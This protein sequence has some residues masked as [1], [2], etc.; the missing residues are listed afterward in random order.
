MTSL[1]DHQPLFGGADDDVLNGDVDA[2]IIHGDAGNDTIFGE[3]GDDS[4]IGG[5]GDDLLFGGSGANVLYGGAGADFLS[6]DSA[7]ADGDLQ[8]LFGGEGDNTLVLEFTQEDYLQPGVINEV[9]QYANAL[10]AGENPGG[11]GEF[12]FTT[13]ALRT[14]GFSEIQIFVDG[15]QLAPGEIPGVNAVD[16][17][18]T[19]AESGSVSGSVV[20]NDNFPTGAIVSLLIGPAGGDLT[21]ENDGSFTFS[22]SGAFE[23]LSN[24]DTETVTFIYRLTDDRGIS[25]AVV[26]IN[27]TGENDEPTAGV[28]AVNTDENQPVSGD[29]I[30]DSGAV[31]IDRNDVLTVLSVNGQ[32]LNG[33]TQAVTLPSGAVIT[34]A[35]AGNYTYAPGAAFDS[36]PDGA[37]DT[38]VIS[39]IVSDGQ[40]GQVASELTVTV[41]GANDAPIANA[42]AAI[43]TEDDNVT[44]DVLGNDTDVDQGDTLTLVSIDSVS[45]G[46]NAVI[47]P[48]GQIQFLPGNAFQTLSVGASA[49]VE[50]A[51]TIQDASGAQSSS[52][53]TVTVTG[54][55]DAPTADDI[56][57]STSEDAA[58]TGN[59]ISEANAQDI[60]S[61]DVLNITE[62][63]GVAFMGG[64]SGPLNS[65][66]ELTVLANGDFTYLPTPGFNG[67][68][69]GET[70]T[71]SFTFTI[72]DGRG[73]V[74][75]QSFTVEVTGENDGPVVQDIT[76]A[77]DEND[78]TS[79]DFLA[80]SNA[81]DPDDNGVLALAAVNGATPDPQAPPIAGSNGGE[82]SVDPGGDFTFDTL[83]DFEELSVGDTETT[84][85]TF[86][87]EDD[88]G[89]TITR[90]L[91]FEVEGTNDDPTADPVDIQTDEDTAA[92][93][94][95]L[96]DS[97]AFDIDQN[98]TLTIVEIRAAG[99]ADGA[100]NGAQRTI[101]LP[102]GASLTVSPD[103][104]YSYTP[105]AQFQSLAEGDTGAANFSFRIADGQGGDVLVNVDVA[106][107]GLND[108]PTADAITRGASEDATAAGDLLADSN[109]ADVDDG[110]V[111]RIAEVNG[112]QVVT[113]GVTIAGAD[114]GSLFVNDQGAYTFNPDGDFEFL[115]V[116]D[117][118]TS[119]FTFR[120]ADSF[121]GFVDQDITFNIAGANDVPLVNPIDSTTDE[122]TA[123]TGNFIVDGGASDIDQNDVLA[124]SRIIADGVADG[125]LNGASRTFALASGAQLTVSPDG[126]Y[127]Y[128][129][130]QAFQS[131]PEGGSGSDTLIYEVVDSNGGSAQESL[132]I[133][134]DGVNDAPTLDAINVT[135]GENAN[136]E[137]DL[138]NDSNAADIDQGDTV[139]IFTV[140]GQGF[141]S[142][143][144]T[145]TRPGEG[146]LVADGATYTYLTLTDFDRLSVGETA[147][148][149][150]DFTVSDAFGATAS[151]TIN[152]TITGEND[153]PTAQDFADTTTEDDVLAGNLLSESNAQDVDQSDVLTITSFEADGQGQID[154]N[155]AEASVDFASGI[156]LTVGPDGAYSFDPNGSFEGLT[157]GESITEEFVFTI[158]DGNGGEITRAASITING[159]N[160]APVAVD[161]AATTDQNTAFDIDILFNDSDVDGSFTLTSFTQP[162]AGGITSNGNDVFFDPNGDFDFLA[163]GQQTT[164]TFTY[165]I[166]DNEGAIDTA[167]VVVTITGLNDDPITS[168]LTATTNEDQANFTF[169]LL[170]GQIDV[171]DGDV[172]SIENFAENTTVFGDF[173]IS[174]SIFTFDAR[175]FDSLDAGDSQ[176]IV[177]DYDVVDAFGARASNQLTL[178]VEG[179]DEGLSAVDDNFSTDEDTILSD[180]VSLND[181]FGTGTY[182]LLQDVDAGLLTFNS[183]GTFT[184]DPNGEFD[185]LADGE[186]DA[187]TFTYAIDDGVQNSSATATI[188]IFGVNDGPLADDVLLSTD[189]DTS[190]SFNLIDESNASDPDGAG[191][192][193]LDS[194]AGVLLPLNFSDAFITLGSG[195]VVQAN[196]DGEITY[197]PSGF[198]DNLSEGEFGSDSFTF[199]L[200]DDFGDSILVSADIDI[201]G[202][203]DPVEADDAS[204]AANEDAGFAG[205]LID[206]SDASDVDASDEILIGDVEGIDVTG[207]D[208]ISLASGA[209]LTID[210]FGN[211]TYDTS[212]AF[213]TLAVGETGSDAFDYSITDGSSSVDLTADI[214]VE[215]ANDDVVI[216]VANSDLA[217]TFTSTGGSGAGG[218]SQ[219]SATEL[220]G[221]NGFA[222]FGSAN[223]LF[224]GSAVAGDG[225]FDGDG[226][227]DLVIGAFGYSPVG[228]SNTGTAFVLFGDG[229]ATAPA[230]RDIPAIIPADDGISLTGQDNELLGREAAFVGD[231][232]GD[233]FDDFLIGNSISNAN[234]ADN[235]VARL[236]FG[237]DF[238]GVSGYESLDASNSTNFI[239]SSTGFDGTR[240][241]GSSVAL[242][243]DI[244]NDGIND[245]I[246]GASFFTQ[247]F[248]DDFGK[249]FVVFGRSAADAPFGETFDLATLDGTNG[250]KIDTGYSLTGT[251]L[252][253][254]ADGI[255]DVNGDGLDDL[256]IGAPREI[257]FVPDGSGGVNYYNTGASYVIYGSDSAFGASVD[258]TNLAAGEG[259]R[260]VDN[261]SNSYLG[262]NV[263][264][265]GDFNGDGIDDF[266]ISAYYDDG[267]RFNTQGKVFVVFGTGSDIA[268][269]LD[270]SL[271]TPS[272]GIEIVGAEPY[273]YA[274]S[275]I[276][277]A[278]DF[279][280][281]GFDDLLIG[282][283]RD[284]EN[285]YTGQAY[286]LFGTDQQFSSPFNLA[287]FDEDDGVLLTGFDRGD[288][289]GSRVSAAGD[290]NEDGFDDVIVGAQSAG[291]DGPGAA[292]VFFGAASGGGSGGG[293]GV[294]VG[295]TGSVFF[296]DVDLTDAH[297]VSDDSV[298]GDVTFTFELVTDSTGGLTGEALWTA[299]IDD[300][301]FAMLAEGETVDS[302][303]NVTIDDGLGGAATETIEVTF[304]GIN[305]APTAANVS[306]TTDEDTIL[307]DGDLI[308]EGSV[309]DID[310]GDIV[311][312]STIS[313]GTDS[314]VQEISL[315]ATPTAITINDAILT[316]DETGA[317]TLDPDDAFEFLGD[318]DMFTVNFNFEAEDLAGATVEASAAITITGI[319]DAPT[320][321]DDTAATD[322]DTDI[323]IS[324]FGND[325]DPEGGLTLLSVDTMGTLATV[326]I[327]DPMAGTITFDPDGNF[328][329]LGAGEEATDTFTYTLEDSGGLQSTAEVEVTVMGL[330]DAPVASNVNVSVSED[331]TVA[332]N[333]LSDGGGLD[334]DQNDTLVV[335]SING[336]DVTG[337]NQTIVLASG[338][339]LLISPNGDFTYNPLPGMLQTLA[340]GDMADDVISVVISDGDLTDTADLVVSV[341]GVNDAPTATPLE[342]TTNEDE[343]NFQID[344]LANAVE[345]DQGDVLSIDAFTETPTGFGSFILTGTDLFYDATIFGDLDAGETQVVD[346][347][348]DIVDSQGARVSTTLQL[349]IEGRDE[350]L[351]A[352]DDNFAT[353]EDTPISGD[354]STN[355]TDQG[356]VFSLVT[357]PNGD[358]T[359]NAD[360]TF[361]YD[362]TTFFG[363]LAVGE[364]ETDTFTYQIDN[365]TDTVTADVTITID[366][367]NDGPQQALPFVSLVDLVSLNFAQDG[368]SNSNSTEPQISGDG[369]VVVFESAS[370]VLVDADTNIAND[371]FVGSASGINTRANIRDDNGEQITDRSSSNPEI[372]GDGTIVVFQSASRQLDILDDAG[373]PIPN[374]NATDVFVRDENTGE[375]EFITLFGVDGLRSNGDSF[376]ASISENGRFVA[377]NSAAT[378]LSAETD[379]NAGISDVFLHDRQTGETKLISQQVGTVE[380]SAS[381]QPTISADGSTVVFLTGNPLEAGDDNNA[382]DVYAYDV[383]SETLELVSQNSASTVGNNDATSAFG[384]GSSTPYVSGNGRYVTWVSN[385]TNLVE[386][387]PGVF[388]GDTNGV[389]DI[390][391][392]DLFF[393]TTERISVSTSGVEANNRSVRPQISDDGRFVSYS[394][395]ASN[396][397][398]ELAD[399]NGIEDAFVYDRITKTTTRVSVTP[400][401]SAQP[402]GIIPTISANGDFI[403]FGSF[404]ANADFDSRV[405]T[406]GPADIYVANINQTGFNFSQNT[407][408][409][410]ATVDL[411]GE[412]FDE[413]GDLLEI[414]NIVVTSDDTDRSFSFSDAQDDNGRVIGFSLDPSEFIDLGVNDYELLTAT[415]DVTDGTVTISGVTGVVIVGEN[416]VPTA[417]DQMFD[418]DQGGSV[419]GNFFAMDI[420]GDE[421]TFSFDPAS[422]QGDLVLDAD[423]T[424]TYTS[425]A[426]QSADETI[427]INV[428]DGNGGLATFEAI[429]NVNLAP[430]FAGADG[431]LIALTQEVD[432]AA[433]NAIDVSTFFAD[434]EGTGLTYTAELADGGSL[435]NGLTIDAVSGV[436]SGT[437]SD[438]NNDLF[439]IAVTATDED[440]LNTT[441]EFWLAVVDQVVLGDN[442]D[443]TIVE[444]NFASFIDGLGGNDNIFGDDQTDIYQYTRGDGFDVLAED[445]F[446][447]RDHLILNGYDSTEISFQR[448]FSNPF[449]DNGFDLLITPSGSAPDFSEG[450]LVRNGLGVDGATARISD[451]NFDDG[452]TITDTEV[453]AMILASEATDGDDDIRG[454]SGA[455]TLAGGLGDDLLAGGDSADTYIINAGEGDDT[456][457]DS[458][459][460]DN[461]EIQFT[462]SF[463]GV[464]VSNQRD[465]DDFLFDF[466]DGSS[467]LV[468]NTATNSNS[469][470]IASYVFSDVTL[471][472]QD[473]RDILNAQQTTAGDDLIFG[474]DF[475]GDTLVG[476]QGDDTLT[477][478]RGDDVYI[479][480]EGDG[481][482]V[483][484]EQG[485]NITGDDELQVS[486]FELVGSDTG[487]GFEVVGSSEVTFTRGLDNLNTVLI[488]L[489]NASGSTGSIL[490]EGGISPN[491]VNDIERLTFE[492]PDGAGGT[493]TIEVT[494]A[495]IRSDVLRQAETEGDDLIVG[496]SGVDT[497]E[498]GQGDDTLIGG[499]GVDTYIF[500]IGDGD[501]VI[502]DNGALQNDDIVVF[503]DRAFADVRIEQVSTFNNNDLIITA[504]TDSI[505]VVGGLSFVS[506]NSVSEYQFTDQTVTR[507]QMRD[508]LIAQAI[509]EG[510][511]PIGTSGVDIYPTTPGGDFFFNGFGGNDTYTFAPGDGDDTVTDSGG[512][513][514]FD[515]LDI[516]A[517]NSTDFIAAGAGRV[518]LN[519]AFEDEAIFEIG[520]DSLTVVGFGSFE[521]IQFA[522]QSF[523]RDGND[524]DGELNFADFIAAN[525]VGVRIPIVG[526]S[527]SETFTSTSADETFVGG[528]GTDTYVFGFDSSGS[529]IGDDTVSQN[530]GSTSGLR[531]VIDFSGTGAANVVEE[532]VRLSLDPNNRFDLVLDVIYEDSAFLFPDV[533][534]GRFEEQ[535]KIND[536]LASFRELNSIEIID[537]EGNSSLLNSTVEI[538]QIIFDQQVTS[539]DD[540]IQGY[541]RSG[542]VF[543]GGAGNDT[544]IGDQ[545]FDTY[546]FFI[547]DEKDLIADGFPQG[548]GNLLQIFDRSVAD[549]TLKRDPASA[550]NLIIDFGDDEVTISNFFIQTQ[551]A[552]YEFNA[553]NATPD[554]F[555]PG[556]IAQLFVDSQSTSGDDLIT[557]GVIF[558]DTLAGG[559]GDDTLRGGDSS[560]TYILNA[561]EGND[562]VGD[563][564]S[565]VGGDVDVLQFD[566]AS[567]EVTFFQNADDPLNF[568]LVYD[569]GGSVEI[570]RLAETNDSFESFVFTDLTFTRDEIVARAFD[571]LAT[572]GDDRII[573]SASDNDL[574]GGLGDDYVRGGNGTDSFT[575]N[576]GDGDD[577]LG[578][579]STA[580]NEFETVRIVGVDIDD[581]VLSRILG[582]R[583]LDSGQ[584][585][586]DEDLLISFANDAGSIVY[587]NGLRQSSAQPRIEIVD[588][589]VTLTEQEIFNRVLANDIANGRTFLEGPA[590]GSVTFPTGASFIF[591][592]QQGD[593]FQYEA[594][595]GALTI[596]DDAPFS[597]TQRLEIT[598]YSS[599]DATF[600]RLADGVEDFIVQLPG[601]D[602]IIVIGDVSGGLPVNGVNEIFF[603][604]DNIIFNDADIT[605]LIDGGSASGSSGGGGGGGSPRMVS[606]TAPEVTEEAFTVT[607]ASTSVDD[608]LVL[609]SSDDVMRL[610]A[611]DDHVRALGGADALW[612][613]AGDDTLIGNGGADT[614]RGGAGEDELRGGGGQDRL[615]GG[616]GDDEL[617]G[618]GGRDLLKGGRG[619]DDLKGGGGSDVL[620]GGGG[621]DRIEGGKGA[622]RLQGQGGEDTFVFARGFGSDVI[623]DFRDGVDVIDFSTHATVTAFGDLAISQVG[624]DAIITDGVGGRIRLL[625]VDENDLQADDF[626]F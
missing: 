513:A 409:I 179:R 51:Y 439:R 347:T 445:G 480:N 260:I 603:A 182:N 547:G 567:T 45:P 515:V 302:T 342:R 487:N 537:S 453:R 278:G 273:N 305:D 609:S 602:Q 87:I 96:S 339:E 448:F 188:D 412:F 149:S 578:A 254:A 13:F 561:N 28:A 197:D 320:A 521:R 524:A 53:A 543:T 184:F 526:N 319:N 584:A 194:L 258:V 331:D 123:T 161:D 399:T 153:G 14:S 122:D 417:E 299:I 209:E 110:D 288:T 312:I 162:S 349:T 200:V 382:I 306:R 261:N 383:E 64:F 353:D 619:E 56:A 243:G 232:N 157:T 594:G 136:I 148:T 442:D 76:I 50:I 31:D 503:A 4:L 529:N 206:L 133:S 124:V 309:M 69:V 604:G 10:A 597:E 115:S 58:I 289:F 315:G 566:V 335:Q 590:T 134:I 186:Q 99:L 168:P 610:G 176:V 340:E 510:S 5:L 508:F 512:A 425:A 427:S 378:N 205:D 267:S 406:G 472:L 207:G 277:S 70:A 496:F 617:R 501:D 42:D 20:T 587:E 373:V 365:G 259:F 625:D 19:T 577:T 334:V 68:G 326:T 66:A 98:D 614:L 565:N 447:E 367:V 608:T 21:L 104:D 293:S 313:F 355:D 61:A 395:V 49:F 532:E 146:S 381:F 266:A 469:D 119:S 550:S 244:N 570:E 520:G 430:T 218:A 59:L 311:R 48:T 474:F 457:R 324:V 217:Q 238:T 431:V 46:G 93:G 172:L 282:A 208:T 470:G 328:D 346:F 116:G 89:A 576:I 497:I 102:D 174:G 3:G 117:T 138:V 464:N 615:I 336:V 444:G 107:D 160:D 359:F 426:D 203:N 144:V 240:N 127:T 150:F 536:A 52:V 224:T 591:A 210:E 9:E 63:D 405:T 103:G 390:F 247:A 621:D 343:D 215:G 79:V 253:S 318:G 509:S 34:V 147:T 607:A 125:A 558:A 528:G 141:G 471:D 348:Y 372:N 80:D 231:V 531:V 241:I 6:Y 230:S 484:I 595:Q 325:I 26:Q 263:T 341:T 360:G 191:P 18:F 573:G 101:V 300:A 541:T 310:N 100:L 435:P 361:D 392:R 284:F 55:N 106:V 211:F 564:G 384:A 228:G 481:D 407:P 438:N 403:A 583:D 465:S 280:G 539:G 43:T 371:I 560:D 120:I 580:A 498:G 159:V 272:E 322:Q 90:T 544:L 235:G 135:I 204:F 248:D 71:D 268:G 623:Q 600:R 352:V 523:D 548:G 379:D 357:T 491:G 606:P 105:G 522:D 415:Y 345:I 575:Y 486:G 219:I 78:A 467:L 225:D 44:F 92:T 354:V 72:S 518:V 60:D 552:S 156:R 15:N 428:E 227:D 180:D 350:D 75:V 402:G 388:D 422:L 283:D 183:D 108:D 574:R 84:T 307:T 173:L 385:A 196:R 549:A 189:E 596:F 441:G 213:E 463:A 338:S 118:A 22:T 83:N 187:V 364:Q 451:F 391:V 30:V 554:T 516:S 245:F 73:G 236:V 534:I 616:G 222:L 592:Q 423:G 11:D 8:R 432:P 126:A 460:L 555:T 167:S 301:V 375:T 178:T 601:D 169:D 461:D 363:S 579:I 557:G 468:K 38:D 262:F 94:N 424:F 193:E 437:P 74:V 490:V 538:S 626:L 620:R 223:N 400:D 622:D 77:V 36:H 440:G 285:Q 292:F 527:S 274:G 256:I 229:Q 308:A 500:N 446:L 452:V 57:D 140:E 398:D 130:L 286:V 535:I 429:F 517:F 495:D 377:F 483:I 473:V 216:D 618:N 264:T 226:I 612:G 421:L 477:G 33:L 195:I 220:D 314:G 139:S 599:T 562:L 275:S 155:G 462:F 370:D 145:I 163:E 1:T 111:L 542:E 546:Q 475:F 7:D 121:G 304:L 410:A 276:S 488:D 287:N 397:D 291:M 393:G 458:G 62:I 485:Q 298:A 605:T 303:V 482:D 12:V 86:T 323:Q 559:L 454:F 389:D 85:F 563:D 327:T 296:T 455:D 137:G 214:T 27:V 316:I 257:Q 380:N 234:G 586:L 553:Q 54:A 190:I 170:T 128:D 369:Q 505:R 419:S 112:Q 294:S 368:G 32:A 321:V 493:D 478:S 582:S 401:L 165:T 499:S 540:L 265:I 269:D 329:T 504:G 17:V 589:G 356:A 506:S 598:G 551:I 332:G 185:A 281:D 91:T 297:T 177:Y 88:Q 279:N 408:L 443:N 414:S 476:G 29:L 344:L 249:A 255:G 97:A 198:F 109:A 82:L 202:V 40:G 624:D 47:T 374:N 530:G 252:G 114:G 568:T 337:A 434:P 502:Q 251:R 129:P 572:D 362:P 317:Y 494:S 376:N 23:T 507:D 418:V 199:E 239:D 394:S 450:V 449:D 613:Q 151:T 466:T 164:S 24:G 416:D 396:L 519:P 588:S 41:N 192:I 35:P 585:S 201:E 479:Y 514:N 212:G 533:G 237:R 411:T 158:S 525:G 2:N 16:D 330:N 333:F 246:I 143:P 611:G 413:D 131:L 386:T 181:T 295:G 132:T 175:Q 65:G 233:G 545:G 358:I 270:L 95:F 436:I 571:D 556:Q 37:S 67:L 420:D 242:A 250:F 142:G 569:A 366:G 351:L 39:F 433:S 113:G 459:F 81:F 593:I 404:D 271:L 166:T 456:I 489:N 154:L 387:S 290:L 492:F 581:V 221:T 511:S 152:F 171:D 25:D